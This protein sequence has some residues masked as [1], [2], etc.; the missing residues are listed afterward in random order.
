MK[1]YIDLNTLKRAHAKNDFEKEFKYNEQQCI[2][3]NYGK[4]KKKS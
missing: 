2:W 1:A 3:K 4:C